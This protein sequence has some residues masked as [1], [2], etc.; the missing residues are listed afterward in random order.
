M[1]VPDSDRW[2]SSRP[3]AER[4]RAAADALRCRIVAGEFSDG[5]IADEQTLAK[6]LGAS[7]NAVRDALALLRD[8]G[9]ISRRRG[10]GTTVVT[11]KYGHGLDRLAGLAEALTGYG[12]VVNEVRVATVVADV[13]ASVRE[14]LELV[15]AEPVVYIERLRRLDGVPLSLDSTYLPA[16]VGRR[17]LDA[18]LAGR[19]LFA[20]IEEATGSLLGRADVAVHA[21]TSD[22]STAASL[23]IAAGDPV[24]H[25]ERLTR[26]ADGRPV[27]AETLRIR[28][29][30]M[31][32]HA[33]LH[34]GPR[35]EAD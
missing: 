26:L 25:I 14:R 29:D 28:A 32:L 10:V 35:L 27:D 4:S 6:Q 21:V 11:P 1:L 13:P 3:R 18:D 2:V 22:P 30:R 24:F 34:R 20:L 15:A 33:T 12:T 17:V 5:V 7:R 19:D 8:E 23:E 31:T 16:D 9:L